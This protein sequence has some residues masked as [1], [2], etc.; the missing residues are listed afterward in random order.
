MTLVRTF[1]YC[2]ALQIQCWLF[3]QHRACLEVQAS[4]TDASWSLKFDPQLQPENAP[5]LET[6]R[7]TMRS[8]SSLSTV[9]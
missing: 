9:G 1:S 5:D 7:G 8:C 2:D 6:I 3:A 4:K